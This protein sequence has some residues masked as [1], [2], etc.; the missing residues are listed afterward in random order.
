M[1][2]LLEFQMLQSPRSIQ[3]LRRLF[4][5]YHKTF[6][7]LNFSDYEAISRCEQEVPEYFN[8]ASDEQKG[9][10]NPAL[11]EE[12][13]FLS[14]KVANV[15]S[16][17]RTTQLTAQDICYRL[18]ASKN[19]C[20]I[21][22]DVLA[23]VVYLVASK[24]QFLKTKIIVSESSRPLFH[25]TFW[26]FLRAAPG[27]P[28]AISF[29]SGSTGSPKMV[30]LSDGSFGLG[31][32]SLWKVKCWMNLIPSD[33]MWNMSDTAWLK[34]A[35]GRR[36]GLWFQGTCV[37]VHAMPQFDLRAIL[38]TLCRYPVTTLCSAPAAYHMLVQRDLTRY[39]KTLKHC[40]TRGEPLNLE[41]IAQWKI[42]EHGSL[43]MG[44][45]AFCHL[46]FLLQIIDE[47]GGVLP[48]GKGGDIAIKMDAKQPFTF[49]SQYLDDPVKTAFTIRV[50]FC[51]TGDIGSM[52]E[53]GNIW[54]MGRSDDVIISSEFVYY[55][56]C[57]VIESAVVSS[58]NPNRGEV[59][60]GHSPIHKTLCVTDSTST[61]FV[62]LNVAI[63]TLPSLYLR[64][65][66]VHVSCIYFFLNE[67]IILSF[68]KN[69]ML[70]VKVS[71][72]RIDVHF[73]PP[74]GEL[75]SLL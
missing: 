3:T 34:A 12:L 25:I 59:I 49:F 44:S 51:I 72:V 1:R 24:C 53:D 29:T 41:V 13:G 60:S 46:P 32:F 23:P 6:S 37:F 16:G 35:I 66:V 11:F 17:P 9:P 31:F 48:P 58:P 2:F 7:P 55:F 40:L 52:D 73:D 5:Q 43:K 28:M 38:N 8:F 14:T 19:R 67:N 68:L 71:L 70:N 18:L 45:F 4:H 64:G 74:P 50:K 21:T 15:L 47:N 39:L 26:V 10:S 75:Y 63:Q 36:F 30:E 56:K 42:L 69:M 54:F 57:P 33:V 27:D 65:A 61:E 20:I 62:R 22:T